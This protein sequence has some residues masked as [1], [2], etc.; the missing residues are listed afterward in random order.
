MSIRILFV[1]LLLRSLQAAA[2]VT[3][4]IRSG[5]QP[6]PGVSVTATMGT[7]KVATST[8]EAGR[9]ALNGLAAGTW[10]I[11]V[12]LFGFAKQ[13]KP[14]VVADQPVQADWTLE[15]QTRPERGFG[16][17]DDGAPAEFQTRNNPG[18]PGPRGAAAPG[19]R[20]APA[21]AQQ[22]RFQNLAL[23]QTA[24]LQAEPAVGGN[25]APGE[26]NAGDA[27]QSFLVSGTISRDAATPQQDFG[28]GLGFGFDQQ[29]Q[30]FGQEGGQA[31]LGGPGGFGAGGGGRGGPG[32]GGGFGGGR[33][34]PGGGGGFGARGGQGRRPGGPG[35]PNFG[36]RAGRRGAQGIHGQAFYSIGNSALNAK[37]YSLTG[38]NVAEPSYG[39]NRFGLNVGGPLVFPKFVKSPNT[40]FFLNYTGTR[41]RS[42]YSAVTT[43]PTALERGGDFSQSLSQL[44]GVSMPVTVYDP[45]TN[46]PFA[47]NVIPQT[48]LNNVS[49]GL[50]S[51][52]PLPNQPGLVNNYRIESA[53]PSN[54]DNLNLRVNQTLTKKDR[55]DGSFGFQRRDGFAQQVFG[56]RDTSS[57]SGVNASIGWSHTLPRQVIN[58]LRI[59]YSRNRTNTLPFFAYGTDVAALLGIE[60]T[61]QDPI[62]FGPPNLSFTNYGALSDGTAALIRNQTVSVTEGVSMVRGAHTFNIGG[63]FRRRQLNNR[64]DADAR[65][66]FS[67]SGLETSGFTANGQPLPGTGYDFA[68]YLLG[69]AQSG[70]V[71]FGDTSTYFRQS[72][73]NAFV[74]DNWRFRPD[75]TFTLGLR[76][77]HFQ[78]LTEKYNHIA[79]LD[80]S[81]D[82][83]N[84]VAVTPGQT[85]PYHG[86]FDDGLVQNR[87]GYLSPRLAL[88]WRP[89]GKRNTIVR[90]GYSI[91]YNGSIFDQFASRLAAQPP[92]AE[93]ASL[94]G[95][96]TQPLYIQ[97]GFL[98]AVNGSLTNSYAVDPNYKVGYAQ[99]WTVSVQQTI[100]QQYVVELSYL[101]TK[102]TD[103]DTQRIPNRSA[104][105]S[106][107]SSANTAIYTYDSSEGNSIY[108]ALQVRATRRFVKGLSAN[109]NYKFSKS[110]DDAST[111]GGG[112][113]VVAQ[114]DLNLSAE[115]GLSS[116]D[117]RH[118]FSAEFVAESPFS[119]NGMAK[120]GPRVQKY[121]GGWTLSGRTNAASGT[122]LTARALGNLSNAGGTGAVGSLRAN[123]TG[124]PLYT[125]DGFFN[126][127]AFTVPAPGAIRERGTQHDHYAVCVHDE[128]VAEP[129]VSDRQRN[130]QAAGVSNGYDELAEQREHHQLWNHCELFELWP[131]FGSHWNAHGKRDAAVEI[132]IMRTLLFLTIAAGT[133]FAQDDQPTFKSSSTL[134]VVD[135]TIKDKAGKEV[136]GLKKEDFV[137]TE[138]GKPQ[139]ISVFE[140]Q[141]LAN[142]DVAPAPAT[143]Q[144]PSVNAPAPAPKPQR[145]NIITTAAPGKLV[146]R[147]R[148]LLTLFFDFS[149]L[150]VTDQSL[151]Q[152]AAQQFIREKMLPGDLVSI[153]SFGTS[154]KVNQDF[155]DDKDKLLQVINS[156][157]IGEASELAAAGGNGDT[158]SGADTGAAFEADQTEF[159]I[160]NTD[161]KLAALESAAKML[162][163]LPEK[164]ALVYFSDGVSKTGV[165]NQSQLRSTINAAV[166]ANVS[167]YPIDVRGLDATPPGGDAS[168][169]A[170]RGNSIYTGAAQQGVR[171]QFN[172]QQETLVS[173]ASDT[174]G[175][176]F[177]DSNDL[178]L[179]ISEARDDVHSYYI[180]GYYSS[181]GTLDGK[182]RRVNV[183]LAGKQYAGLK[184]DYRSGY[185]GAKDFRRFNSGDK[186]AQLQEALMLG[187]PITDLPL[188]I[189]TD[190]FRL[191]KNK[192][193]IPVSIK[194]PGSAIALAMKN[195][196]GQTGF[197]VIGQ[198][199]DSKG[200]VAASVEDQVK[201]KLDASKTSQAQ[202]RSFQYDTG[203]TLPPGPYQFKVLVRENQT[204][205]MGT[206]EAK[207]I[208]PDLDNAKDKLR[209]SSVVWSN[210]LAPVSEAVGVADK[211]KKAGAGNPLIADGQKLAP[212]ITRVF[213]KDQNLY[214]YLEVYDPAT[215]E[216][217]GT[218][219]VSS[220]LTF[221]RASDRVKAFESQPVRLSQTI[222]DRPTALPVRFQVPLAKLTPGRYICQVNVFDQQARKFSFP[223]TELVLLP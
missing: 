125:G 102:G 48:R 113:I 122:P 77:E 181:N 84:A 71:R 202:S 79:N 155:T 144:P 26:P 106:Y 162:G 209:L 64:T 203:F 193:F 192:Y 32:G 40:F 6:I 223:R 129:R 20:G 210:Q 39:S 180:L 152:K 74:T 191:N 206:F 35:V 126:P 8:D 142:G 151:A 96:V 51:Y 69:L 168:Q 187:D 24:E 45:T 141:R 73:E 61:S 30:G 65:G 137:I 198:M 37:P 60:G 25:P 171:D 204:G 212:S 49:L 111:L 44:S 150:S 139:P 190:Y 165:E 38:Q 72:Q 4:V 100:K 130:T 123:A 221:Y 82:F 58:N 18:G 54:S 196:A 99:T 163:A 135:V 208:V 169:A 110:I 91:F 149:S 179:G 59:T 219:A 95:S 85:G 176:A 115:R 216:T 127:L 211:S 68:D 184:L 157:R 143:L 153:L 97:N 52:V 174:G 43:V 56:F 147:D 182:L 116:F 160:F 98:N 172:N 57:G 81:P 23:T 134:V 29:N 200:H 62:N 1:F 148:R 159:N 78:P 164:K 189:E 27:N 10:Q 205:K 201:V 53:N 76:Y 220:E 154:L 36:N 34:G 138:D 104:Q 177:L 17:R 11:D 132:L 112:A 9:Y 124:L 93:T 28:P 90:A 42:P 14:V 185:F 31:G 86:K 114:N 21:S 213:K 22:S 194:I 103:L 173:L 19:Q 217:S 3:G 158:S 16:R 207:V 67:F 13:Q 140:F 145:Q 7:E 188:A 197:D 161:L 66:S 5:G 88:A 133:L 55:L 33:G 218:P 109:L 166:R 195:G 199:R 215:N 120:S 80:I 108:H 119:E 222:A 117:Q 146:Y 175:K 136:T 75:L 156:F 186:D 2:P 121:F 46:A 128:P 94:V 178:A 89:K 41:Q 183:K 50:L 170:G 87:W 63:E 107:R 214:V 12:A 92:F 83:K 47:G 101:G 15:I 167:F 105:G 131:A 118:V 70:S